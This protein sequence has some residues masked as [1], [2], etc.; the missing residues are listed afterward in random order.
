MPSP[1]AAAVVAVQVIT[2]AG[3]ADNGLVAQS[4]TRG[5]ESALA[6]RGDSTQPRAPPVHAVGHDAAQGSAVVKTKVR[7]EHSLGRNMGPGGG[8]AVGDA[9]R[10]LTARQSTVASGVGAGAAVTVKGTA[11]QR[12]SSARS[13]S[14]F[15]PAP[16]GM[17]VSGAIAPKVLLVAAPPPQPLLASTKTAATAPK[18][19]Q[20]V[21]H[22]ARIAQQHTRSTSTAGRQQVPVRGARIDPQ[23]DRAERRRQYEALLCRTGAVSHV[24]EPA[25][26]VENTAMTAASGDGA[27]A[28]TGK[29]PGAKPQGARATVHV[30][31][32][33]PERLGVIRKAPMPQP[34][35]VRRSGS[36]TAGGARSPAGATHGEPG[37]QPQHAKPAPNAKNAAVPKPAGRASRAAAGVVGTKST[38][39]R[40]G[41][42]RSGA[43]DGP[44]LTTTDTAAQV[45]DYN[46][47][48]SSSKL[49]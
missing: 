7:S 38:D 31:L 48:L 47:R 15:K 45:G 10:P 26:A 22:E 20:P 9:V 19:K 6:G 42:C 37:P 11:A 46:A 33:Q 16:G 28:A 2:A 13:G 27:M 4:N 32:P 40:L 17:Q 12:S 3:P 49:V 39:E 18:A 41:P 29:A 1:I 44:R 21:Q 36:A 24:Q 34:G 8:S 23:Q 25:V 14:V 43:D 30:S 5:L 35:Q